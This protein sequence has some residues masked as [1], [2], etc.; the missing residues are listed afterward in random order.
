LLG[1]IEITRLEYDWIA[2]DQFETLQIEHPKPKGAQNPLV[3]RR[4]SRLQRRN[5]RTENAYR[6]EIDVAL[7]RRRNVYRFQR[8]S[9]HIGSNKFSGFKEVN[10]DMIAGSSKFQSKAKTWLRR[11]LRVFDNL[12]SPKIRTIEFLLDYILEIMKSTSIK[13]GRAEELLIEYLGEEETPLFLHE[14][15]SWMRSPFQKLEDWD[16]IIQYHQNSSIE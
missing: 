8:Y 9:M 11:E 12:Q 7:L 10:P 13:S 15:S 1:K 14:L 3:E 5:T 16:I 6:T 4:T 2:P